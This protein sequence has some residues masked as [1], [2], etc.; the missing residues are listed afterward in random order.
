MAAA[1]CFEEAAE[2]YQVSAELLRAIAIVESGNDP[3]AMNYSHRQRTSSHDIGLLQINSQHL[4]ALAKYGITEERLRTDACLN[5]KVGAWILSDTLRRHGND[6]NGVGA[7]NAACT[8][9]KGR[10]CTDARNRYA[11]KVYRAMKRE[12]G[13]ALSAR[14]PRVR[15]ERIAVLTIA[16]VPMAVADH[17]NSEREAD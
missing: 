9:L 2:Q 1:H 15:S 4:P 8:Q 17:N 11:W 6:W 14:P 13:P 16:P 10:D 5:T 3:R 7:Y 12:S